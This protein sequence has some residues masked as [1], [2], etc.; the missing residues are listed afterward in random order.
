LVIDS[1][2][3]EERTVGSRH[4]VLFH[5]QTSLIR[6]T[7]L[8]KPTFLAFAV[9]AI[10]AFFIAQARPRTV[11]QLAGLTAMLTAAIQLWK[12]HAAGSYVEWYYPFLIIALLLGGRGP[13][14]AEVN[15][16]RA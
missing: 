4:L 8:F 7:S 14:A 1:S 10:A 11:A 3:H 13:D 2:C 9:L 16:E 12:T 6:G 5:W 15:D